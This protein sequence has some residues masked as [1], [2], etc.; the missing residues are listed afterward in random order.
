MVTIN[1]KKTLLLITDGGDVMATFTSGWCGGDTLITG[2]K[3]KSWT[4]N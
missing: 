3:P 4:D 2:T 1:I